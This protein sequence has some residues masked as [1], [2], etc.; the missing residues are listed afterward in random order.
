MELTSFLSNQEVN[1]LKEKNKIDDRPRWGSR[2]PPI[3]YVKASDKDPFYASMKNRK[4]KYMKK[5]DKDEEGVCN[6]KDCPLVSI[7]TSAPLLNRRFLKANNKSFCSD[8]LPIKTDKNGKVYLLHE[9]NFIIN[10]A[11]RKHNHQ[12]QVF[13]STDSENESILE[14]RNNFRNSL[15]LNDRIALSKERGD[16]QDIFVD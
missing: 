3:K 7:K 9:E 10:E 16:F 11:L 8:M 5:P 12:Q 6:H 14:M 4:K 13:R 1:K 15:K 2:V